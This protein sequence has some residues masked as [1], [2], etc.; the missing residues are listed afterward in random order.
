MKAALNGTLPC[1][2]RDGWVEEIELYKVG[3]ALDDD[4]L[5]NNILD[6]LEYDIIPMYYNQQPVWQ[7]HMRNAR[8]LIKNKFS[9]TRMLGEYQERFYKPLGVDRA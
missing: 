7:E 4:N 9:T 6:I 3:W 2:T 8:E 5:P 1:S